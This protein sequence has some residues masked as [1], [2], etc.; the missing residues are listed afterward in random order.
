MGQK[1]LKGAWDGAGVIG[2]W[3]RAYKGLGRWLI[4]GLEKGLRR[5]FSEGAWEGG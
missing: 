2:N 4:R 5:G 1:E 3:K